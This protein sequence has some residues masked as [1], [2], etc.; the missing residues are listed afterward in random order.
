[1]SNVPAGG[2]GSG[3]DGPAPPAT[4]AIGDAG[5]P[6]VEFSSTIRKSHTPFRFTHRART[7][8]GRGYSGSGFSDVSSDPHRLM[9]RAVAGLQGAGAGVTG[10]DVVSTATGD[11]VTGIG[12]GAGAQARATV[13]YARRVTNRRGVVIR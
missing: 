5:A 10:T 4:D 8:C 1:M 3:A 2:S 12:A 6:G 7:I 13:R 9:S 11:G